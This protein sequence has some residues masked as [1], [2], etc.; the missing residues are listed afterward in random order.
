MTI[1]E[2]IIRAD[3]PLLPL[4]VAVEDAGGSILLLER[5]GP[6]AGLAH[7]LLPSDPHRAARCREL[8][9]DWMTAGAWPL[10]HPRHQLDY[11]RA[12]NAG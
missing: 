11:A 6:R 10:G 12:S 8:I 7:V 9:D 2:L 4:V 5:E 3:R 1:E